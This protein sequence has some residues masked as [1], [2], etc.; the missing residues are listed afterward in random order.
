MS[1]ST[2][3]SQLQLDRIVRAEQDVAY[4]KAQTLD[5]ERLEK[6][7][8]ERLRNEELLR[9]RFEQE[10]QERIMKE[11][12]AAYSRAQNDW[13]RWVR[14]A[15]IPTPQGSGTVKFA[16]RLPCGKRY[17]GELPSDASMEAIHLFVETLLIP[18]SFSPE[19]DPEISPEGY[20]HCWGFRLVTTNARLILPN[21][22]N[23]RL[24][25]LEV[26]NRGILIIVEEITNIDA[27]L[28]ETLGT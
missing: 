21:D 15:L 19:D 5:R 10:E 13:R 22:S 4:E 14:R 16:V 24:C 7:R 18:S 25:E 2:F 9:K 27:S 26:M 17:I 12:E 1:E 20:K 28:E 8:E 11:E 6:L 23:S 3:A